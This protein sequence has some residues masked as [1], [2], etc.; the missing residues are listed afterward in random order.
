M[1]RTFEGAEGNPLVASEIGM[2]E[3]CI[4]LLHGGGQTR[5]AWSRTAR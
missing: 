4:L 1:S 5:H 2:A 3:R